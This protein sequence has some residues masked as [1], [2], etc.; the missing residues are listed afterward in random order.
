MA[1][2][3]LGI[4]LGTYSLKLALVERTFNELRLLKLVEQPLNLQT[5]LP[6]EELVRLALEQVLQAHDLDADIVSTSYPGHLFSNRILELPPSQQK[7]LGQAVDFDLEGLIPFDLGDV[8][9]DFHL[10]D[11]SDKALHVLCSYMMNEKFGRYI[12]NLASAGVDP[13]YFGADV[14]D[15]S[16]V[17]H[18]AMVPGSEYYALCDIGH[19]K[20]NVCVMQGRELKYVRTIGIGGLHFTRTIQ[21][22]FNVNFE[23]A[24]SLKLSRGKLHIREADADQI[25]R[26]LS[27]VATEL[28]SGI[29]Q[30]FLGFDN[31]S[32]RHTISAIYVTGGSSKLKGLVDYLSF[33]LRT[34][35]LE[36][37]AVSPLPST[38]EDAAEAS[39]LMTQAVAN[40]VK[41][42]FSTK[43][44]RL[45][46]RK[47]P[48][49]FKQELNLLTNELKYAAALTVVIFVLGL[50]YYFYTGHY[51][52]NKKVAVNEHVIDRLE[53]QHKAFFDLVGAQKYKKEPEN[54]N[55]EAVLKTAKSKIATL[56]KQATMV[57]SAT[58]L[59]VLAV[60]QELSK[61]LP[62]KKDVNLEITE[63]DYT[64]AYLRVN[65]LTNDPLNVDK[66]VFGLKQEPS[67]FVNVNKTDPK[68]RAQSDLWEFTM[69][70][71]FKKN[72][73]TDE[74]DEDDDDEEEES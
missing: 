32:A 6:H 64:D 63:F 18:V 51:Y 30:T 73:A 35:V 13:K 11:K 62:Q 31:L 43:V 66:I 48:Y 47:G 5:R 37:D 21:R 50:G 34:N 44:P 45:N 27:H 69:R 28:A 40:A 70:I 61:K 54:L 59:P 1:Q 49:A 57:S 65:A 14:V 19:S 41:P 72:A 9:Y 56:Q 23:K 16:A 29:K 68:R 38:L 74:D 53:N 46:F 20:T 24:E 60:M 25:S 22:A 52:D 10:L 36:L 15:L 33:H 2:K 39:S 42:V 8:F 67:L 12:E 55:P 71:D 7:H 17:A 3:I 4:D 58:N 26:I